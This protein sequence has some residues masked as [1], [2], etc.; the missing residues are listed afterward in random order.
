MTGASAKAALP[1]MQPPTLQIALRTASAVLERKKWWFLSWRRDS[2]RRIDEGGSEAETEL[3]LPPLPVMAA[4]VRKNELA[5]PPQDYAASSEEWGTTKVWVGRKDA[6][7]LGLVAHTALHNEDVLPA[8]HPVSGWCVRGMGAGFVLVEH[9]DKG[10]LVCTRGTRSRSSSQRCRHLM[11]SETSDRHFK[12]IAKDGELAGRS[13][14]K[15]CRRRWCG[16]RS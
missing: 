6:E 10:V 11:R 7:P 15:V 3:L 13:H 8:G 2:A 5:C 9:E 16:S 1:L 4:A 14:R 12:P